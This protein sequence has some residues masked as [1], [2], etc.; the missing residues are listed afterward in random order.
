M[1]PL[2]PG[3]VQKLM[4]VSQVWAILQCS[5]MSRSRRSSAYAL[6]VGLLMLTLQTLIRFSSPTPPL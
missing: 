4:E 6:A 2:E 1:A 3:L 5:R